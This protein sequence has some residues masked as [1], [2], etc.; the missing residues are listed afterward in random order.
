[1][2]WNLRTLVMALRGHMLTQPREIGG[3]STPPDTQRLLAKQSRFYGC[4][5]C[6]SFHPFL[7]GDVNDSQRSDLMKFQISSRS[8]AQKTRSH[9]PK[10][11]KPT[12]GIIKWLDGALMREIW[13]RLTL[14]LP[15]LVAIH[16]YI[17]PDI[18][19]QGYAFLA[20]FIVA[21]SFCV[22]Y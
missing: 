1:M 12:Q 21:M 22:T 4:R 7:L 13:R 2:K 14:G 5:L 15:F 20:A 3:I 10:M 16:Y 8:L 17:R 11:L 19:I 6:G 9:A 18:P